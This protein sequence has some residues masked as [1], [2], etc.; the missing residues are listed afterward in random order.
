[1]YWLNKNNEESYRTKNHTQIITI[2]EV[3][4]SNKENTDY[5]KSDEWLQNQNGI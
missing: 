2:Q 4:K 5:I 3:H 1:M